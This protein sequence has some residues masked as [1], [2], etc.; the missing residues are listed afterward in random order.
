MRLDLSLHAFMMIIHTFDTFRI[1]ALALGALINMNSGQIECETFKCD[2][3]L[4]QK[5][6][7]CFSNELLNTVIAL[8]D[9][10]ILIYIYIYF[11]PYFSSWCHSFYTHLHQYLLTLLTLKRKTVFATIMK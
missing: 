4:F 2:N 9:S 10:T 5:I 11:P 1:Q 3:E 8:P 7:Q 6:H